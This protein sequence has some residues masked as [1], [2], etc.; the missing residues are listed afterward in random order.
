MYRKRHPK[1]ICVALM[2]YLRVNLIIIP[3]TNLNVDFEITP[4]I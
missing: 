2:S 1:Q 3:V 4:S